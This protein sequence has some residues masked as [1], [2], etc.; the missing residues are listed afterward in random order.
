MNRYSCF[1]HSCLILLCVICLTA[2]YWNDITKGPYLQN[3][4]Q[5]QITIM[6]E[7]MESTSSRIDYGITRD[8][9]LFVEDGT[10]VEIHEIILQPLQPDT[11]YYYKITCDFTSKSSFFRTS[12][13]NDTPFRF[14]AYGDSRSHPDDHSQ[15]AQSIAAVNPNFI[16]HVGDMVKNGDKYNQWEEQFFEPLEYIIDHIPIFPCLGNHERNSDNYY[17]L[18][19]L[20]NNEAWYSFDYGNSH[21][22]ALDSNKPTKSG[23]KQYEWLENDLK[24]SQAQWKFVFFH[25]PPYSSGTHKSDISVRRAW[26]PLFHKYGVDM[27]FSGHDHLYERS[28]PIASGFKANENPV[29]YIVTGGGG[30]ELHEIKEE[31]L[32]T[33]SITK[34]YN[35]SLIEVFREKL[36]FTALDAK[37]NVLDTFN[38]QKKLG[39][40]D[41]AYLAA[42][43]P[44]EQI[45]LK[46]TFAN[47]VKPPNLGFIR[48][49]DISGERASVT[50]KNVFPDA[51][52]VTVTWDD[53]NNWRIKPPSRGVTIAKDANVRIPFKFTNTRRNIYPIPAFTVLYET[54]FGTGKTSGKPIKVGRRKQ[55]RCAY[56]LREPKLDGKLKEIYWNP[57]KKGTNF[58]KSDGQDIATAKTTVQSVCGDNAIYFALVCYDDEPEEL[59]AKAKRRDNFNTN[60][61]AAVIYIA[62][63]GKI[64]PVYQFAFNYKGVKY[65]AK[66]GYSRW[67][68]RWKVAVSTNKNGW[69]AEVAIPYGVLEL[70]GPPQAGER[71]GIN[72]H[73]NM[74]E[75]TERSEWS[76]TLDAPLT[77]KM[78]G[79]LIIE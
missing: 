77:A 13:S 43:I 36:V 9:D 74:R 28:Y 10:Q 47:N 71:W 73:R 24:Q 37:G 54:Q 11:L 63:K 40:Y 72:F 31:N 39:R 15:A 34:I 76:P 48:D 4:S 65:D 29:T 75:K 68:A 59:Y 20:P 46:R 7:T 66:N 22:V 19:S 6:W 69:T 2:C 79:V 60:D 14:V 56:V 61:D 78:L 25:H 23:T 12:P 50:V 35:F 55:L 38:I 45:E 62:P 32:W 8:Y 18:F 27:V 52:D 64:R 70:W 57:D 67:S 16:I 30:A 49:V 41:D 44:Y 51:I 21:F 53:S 58:I 5:T 33:A 26:T 3:V 17:N 1:F 42:A